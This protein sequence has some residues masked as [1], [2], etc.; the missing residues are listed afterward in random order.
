M[1]YERVVTGLAI[2]PSA[3]RRNLKL[4][5]LLMLNTPVLELFPL[6]SV[7]SVPSV[8]YLRLVPDGMSTVIFMVEVNTCEPADTAGALSCAEPNVDE[9]LLLPGVG[10]SVLAHMSPPSVVLAKLMRSRLAG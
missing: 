10:L 5:V 2:M 6:V 4:V 9:L 1:I 7:G 3:K 8:V